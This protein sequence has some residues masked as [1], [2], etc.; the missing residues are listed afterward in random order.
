MKAIRLTL[1]AI[2]LAVVGLWLA[3]S[4]PSTAAAATEE[5]RLDVGLGNTVL[6]ANERQK[7]YL[8][9]ALTGFELENPEDRAPVNIALVLDKSGSMSGEKIARARQA[10]WMAVERLGAEDIVSVVVYDSTVNVLVPAT[11]ASDRDNIR[12]AIESI[13]ANGNTALFAGVSK[14]AAELRKFLDPHR[15]NRI[16]L[17]SDGLANVGPSSPR[18]LANLGASLVRDGISVSTIG[19]G[20]GYNEDL[21]TRLAFASDGNHYFAESARQL[22]S[23]FDSEL[24]DVLSV[25]AQEVITE[26]ECAPDV[27]PLRILGRDGEISGRRVKVYM[28]QLYSAHEQY[29]LIE[30]E[31]PSRPEAER[32]EL[33]KVSVHYDNLRTR[34]RDTLS[35]HVDAR[36]SSSPELVRRSEDRNVM[37]SVVEQVAAERSE[38]ATQLRDEGRV[39][40]A[41]QVLRDS[42]ELLGRSA[43]QYSAPELQFYG[44]RTAGDADAIGSDDDWNRQ[45][46]AMREEQT[47]IR[48]QRR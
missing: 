29:V 35:G 7:A 42:A 18:E 19:L 43:E 26:I 12:D 10:A 28:N 24:G 21:M 46:K 32:V 23:I 9:V 47:N 2:A 13:H 1:G 38:Q 11:K 15:V 39:Q 30:V 31:V 33:A 6:L 45:R 20:L 34:K 8:R 37:I 41:Q 14:G 44:E 3:T 40:E 48:Q 22:A 4:P 25:V 16:I 27:R 17:L 5:V 36:F